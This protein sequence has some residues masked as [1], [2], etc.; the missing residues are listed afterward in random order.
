[1]GAYGGQDPAIVPVPAGVVQ[2]GG[3]PGVV[4]P[5]QGRNPAGHLQGMGEVGDPRARPALP[6][7]EIQRQVQA[8][9]EDR[10]IEGHEPP[11]EWPS[12]APGMRQYL[13]RR[14]PSH[15]GTR[16]GRVG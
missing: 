8:P 9:L 5:T 10:A 3:E 14:R 12:L 16:A 7:V 4:V 11:P 6:L 2:Q 13:S 15:T 1:M